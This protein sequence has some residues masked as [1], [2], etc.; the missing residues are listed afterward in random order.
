MGEG[1][2]YDGYF[3]MDWGWWCLMCL[4]FLLICWIVFC[5]GMIEV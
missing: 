2:G 4:I 3:L 5:F 1:G